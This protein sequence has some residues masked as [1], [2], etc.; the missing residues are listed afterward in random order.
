[1]QNY[2]EKIKVCSKQKLEWKA[3]VRRVKII[4]KV[5]CIVVQALRG[6]SGIAL[7]YRH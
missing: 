4:F 3:N 5:K 2:R 6:S 7:L 1:M